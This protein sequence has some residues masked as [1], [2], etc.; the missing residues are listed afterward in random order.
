MDIDANSTATEGDQSTPFGE[1]N[2]RRLIKEYFSEFGA[3]TAATAWEHVYGLLLWV[4][5][6]TGLAHCYESDKCQPGRSW[7]ARSLA[8]HDWLSRTFQATPLELGKRLDWLFQKALEDYIKALAKEHQGQR[9]KGERQRA[10]YAGQDFPLPGADPEVERIISEALT[11][12]FTEPPPENLFGVVAE[13]LREYWKQENKR[14]NLLG[15]GFEDVLAAVVMA[16]CGTNILA[17]TR[18]SIA[19]VNGFRTLGAKDKATKVDVIVEH[20]RWARP[21][22]INVKWS[23]RADREDQLW[24]DFKE[25]VRFD[26]DQRGFD[27]YLITNEFDP[28]RL[29][30]VCDRREANNFIFKNVVH[31]NTDGVLAAYG[32]TAQVTSKVKPARDSSIERVR[33]QVKDGRLISLSKWLQALVEKS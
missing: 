25:Y 9:E 16:V 11:P 3:P 21:T 33:Q 14:K 31:I 17:R 2:R 26:G 22:L 27:H 4:D 20:P 1:K 32:S 28:A 24:D 30:A 8:F 7:Y 29:N 12:Y 19:E 10:V 13:R 15:E 23:I 6:T 18:T 5:R